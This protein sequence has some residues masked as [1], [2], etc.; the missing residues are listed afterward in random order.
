MAGMSCGARSF[1]AASLIVAM[2]TALPPYMQGRVREL[3]GVHVP[4]GQRHQGL[5]S[6]L[7]S[8]TLREAKRKNTVLMLT[9]EDDP[10]EAFYA[11]F[12][13]QA[14]QR[15]PKILMVYP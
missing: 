8:R 13:F 7:L 1:G 9:V 3:V 6:E 14:I 4:E 12:G 11:R 10:L 15:T 5:A 2:P